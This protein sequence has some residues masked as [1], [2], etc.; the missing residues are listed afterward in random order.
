VERR[1]RRSADIGA[2]T[3]RRHLGMAWKTL[4]A[5]SSTLILNI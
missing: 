1:N 5:T 2:R 4:L 3:M